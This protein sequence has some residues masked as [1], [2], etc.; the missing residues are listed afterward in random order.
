MHSKNM[1]AHNALPVGLECRVLGSADY[2]NVTANVSVA[3]DVDSVLRDSLLLLCAPNLPAALYPGCPSVIAYLSGS[4]RHLNMWVKIVH[5]ATTADT[6]SVP[7]LSG[8][9]TFVVFSSLLIPLSHYPF[10]EARCKTKL[11]RN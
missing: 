9:Q 8:R 5:H 7:N 4:Q 11:Q 1:H 6:T 3:M 10:I 2:C